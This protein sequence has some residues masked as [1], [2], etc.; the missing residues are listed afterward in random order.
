MWP[1]FSSEELDRD[2]YPEGATMT[3]TPVSAPEGGKWFA[4]TENFGTIKQMYATSEKASDIPLPPGTH[5]HTAWA[6]TKPGTYTI[7]V[8]AHA[9]QASNGERSADNGEAT[10][11]TQR[12]TFV[13]GEQPGSDQGG[14]EGQDPSGEYPAQPGNPA[15]DAGDTDGTGAEGDPAG[16]GASDAGDSAP[17]ASEAGGASD[18][19][20]DDL[21]GGLPRTG[22]SVGLTVAAA[23]ALAAGGAALTRRRKNS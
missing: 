8:T 21:L 10:A 5:M 1:G 14:A 6:F 16:A 13:V 7:D 4:Y 3:L 12:L 19:G 23:T 17:S 20:G 15:G 9:K 18:A 2:K 11:K 22:A